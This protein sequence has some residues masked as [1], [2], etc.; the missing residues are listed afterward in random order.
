MGTISFGGQGLDW[1]VASRMYVCMYDHSLRLGGH[2]IQSEVEQSGVELS[3]LED[4]I[5]LRGTVSCVYILGD[6]GHAK[7]QTDW[8]SEPQF[9]IWWFRHWIQLSW[10]EYI[11]TNHK[12]EW[13]SL[14]LRW[15]NYCGEFHTPFDDLTYDQFKNY[16]LSLES[17]NT[18][19]FL[20]HSASDS[21][22]SIAI[23]SC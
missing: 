23:A 14:Y 10:V 20:M 11:T 1:P 13:E 16:F 19:C 3:H 18:F 6:V 2:Q 8:I 21:S 17:Y 22:T 15:R 12:K 7:F 9:G 5:R 4:G